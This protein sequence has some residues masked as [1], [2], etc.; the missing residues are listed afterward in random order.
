ME[1]H[2]EKYCFIESTMLAV[3]VPTRVLPL[4]SCTCREYRVNLISPNHLIERIKRVLHSIALK[5]F[6]C[7]RDYLH[8]RISFTHHIH[9]LRKLLTRSFTGAVKL[10]CAARRAIQTI[11]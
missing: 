2:S 7:I 4:V 6:W 5:A 10:L 9:G 8:V 1:Q 3:C 11:L